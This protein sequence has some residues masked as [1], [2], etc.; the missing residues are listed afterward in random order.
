M[1]SP[2]KQVNVIGHADKAEDLEAKAI[3]GCLDP[4]EKPSLVGFV[5]KDLLTRVPPRHRM[6]DRAGILDS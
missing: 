5:E 3:N 1:G 4:F 2:K 6:V